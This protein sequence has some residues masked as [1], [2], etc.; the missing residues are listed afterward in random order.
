MTVLQM[1]KGWRAEKEN[2]QWR[3]E[4]WR[5]DSWVRAAWIDSPVVSMFL[6]DIAAEYLSAM[7]PRPINTAP[8][9]QTAAECIANGH[10]GCGGEP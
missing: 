5:D 6:D 1:P 9:T 3:L 10:C 7:C 4:Q 2:G 8:D